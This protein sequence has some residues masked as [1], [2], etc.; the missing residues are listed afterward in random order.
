MKELP[1]DLCSPL[2]RS[3]LAAW[4]SGTFLTHHLPISLFNKLGAG[5]AP[6]MWGRLTRVPRPVN[7]GFSLPFLPPHSPPGAHGAGWTGSAE[8]RNRLC[9]TWGQVAALSQS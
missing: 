8:S 6:R 7:A 2:R 1:T 9:F 5:L 3:G 4:S